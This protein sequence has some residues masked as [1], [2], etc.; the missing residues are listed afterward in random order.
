M[1][2]KITISAVICEFDPFHWGHLALL[3]RAG[4]GGAAVCCLMSG[5]FL[6]RGAPAMLDKWARA[7]AALSAGADLVFELPLPWAC[8]GAERFASGG[9]CLAGAVGASRLFFGSELADTNALRHLAEALLSPEFARILAA[10]PDRGLPFASRRQRA[11]EALLGPEAAKALFMPNAILGVEYIKAIL[12]QNLDIEPVA[13]LRAGAGHDQQAE[14]VPGAVLSASQLRSLAAQGKSLRGLVPDSTYHI[15]EEARALGRFPVELG[16]LERAV[17]CKLRTLSPSDFAALPDV[18]E[19]LENRLARAVREAASL[20]ELYGRV[21]SKR[22]S[23]ARVRRLVMAAFLGLREPLPA[24]PPYLRLLGMTEKG[25]LALRQA[26]PSLPLA[27]RAGDFQKL[28]P[29]AQEIFWLEVQA[30]DLY[31]LASPV[32]QPMGRDQRELFLKPLG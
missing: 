9:V 1:P 26:A 30:D 19:G 2:E 29:M 17:L 6:Q 21:K 25:R 22:Y 31:A 4:A 27:V 32:P 24:L 18:S 15:M 10:Q 11:A 3:E 7:K 16:R 14:P 5:N 13:V 12:A 23:H 8:A 20:E 28:P